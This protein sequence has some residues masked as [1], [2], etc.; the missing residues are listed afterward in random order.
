M[1]LTNSTGGSITLK[2]RDI[3]WDR[4]YN[5]TYFKTDLGIKYPIDRGAG[6]DKFWC[7]IKLVD[8]YS[9][10]QTIANFIDDAIHSDDPT[11]IL[12]EVD[13]EYPFGFDVNY[14]LDYE[15]VIDKVSFFKQSTLN[16]YVLNFVMRNDQIL[17][18]L[19]PSTSFPEIQ[20][21]NHDYSADESWDYHVN[22]TYDNFN[23][24]VKDRGGSNKG[25]FMGKSRMEIDTL[26]QLQAYERNLRGQSFTENVSV[27]TGGIPIWGP[28][29]TDPTA[30]VQMEIAS[31]E[32]LSHRT[33]DVTIKYSNANVV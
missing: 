20:C 10:L 25:Q 12:S 19:N 6:G 29:D 21:F 13:G 5:W 33:Y 8:T 31:V 27:L 2:V 16:T 4:S 30:V 7:D 32:R 26:I 9:E 1:K 24:Y 23:Q 15:V 22:T 28:R 3:K 17:T 14:T 11:L 18:F